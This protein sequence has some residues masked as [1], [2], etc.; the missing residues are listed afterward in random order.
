MRR[1]INVEP[2]VRRGAPWDKLLNVAT[3]HGAEIIV[4]GRHGQRGS[5]LGLPLGTV[6]SRVLAL[7]TRCVLVGP[8]SLRR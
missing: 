6:A 2:F 8:S 7:S 3:E 1:G 5:I 4:V